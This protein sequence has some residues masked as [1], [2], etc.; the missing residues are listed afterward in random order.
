[1]NQEP[2]YVGIDVS[3]SRHVGVRPGGDGWSMAY[4][5][6]GIRDLASRL[7]SLGPAAVVL[8]AT[9]GLEVPLV[10]SLTAAALPVVV[11]NPRQVHN[12]AAL[13]S[14]QGVRMI[15]NNLLMVY[16]SITC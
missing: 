6:A 3:K 5:E 14:A 9:G 10:A 15:V 12:V 7:Q 16:D 13:D 11:V 4:D 1:M 2:I 8:E